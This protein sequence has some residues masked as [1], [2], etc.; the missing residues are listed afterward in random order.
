MNKGGRRVERRA[1]QCQGLQEFQELCA[2]RLGGW[3]DGQSVPV[4]AQLLQAA[5]LISTT[6][7][8]EKLPI[9]SGVT[10]TNYYKSY[11]E[12][13]ESHHFK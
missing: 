10:T 3:T 4:S 2:G 1:R 12:V 6:R 8:R 5:W 7:R 13:V 11:Q 9:V